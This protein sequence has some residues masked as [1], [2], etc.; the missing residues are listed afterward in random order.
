MADWK[1][2]GEVP[3]SEDEFDFDSQQ[4]TT[5]LAGLKPSKPSI[6]QDIDIWDV[7]DSGEEDNSA[8]KPIV[9]D[10]GPP[11]NSGSTS[12]LSSAMSFVEEFPA[13]DTISRSQSVGNN[14]GDD[15]Q[16]SQVIDL[17]LS[18]SV[19]KSYVQTT[20]PTLDQF[21]GGEDVGGSM[22]R[23][24]SPIRQHPLPSQDLGHDSGHGMDEA[25]ETAARLAAI[26]YERSLRPRKPI[27]EHPY[28]LEN[29]HY[30]S[31]FK[32][33]GVKPV[34]MQAD[35]VRRRREQQLSQEE[36]FQEESQ[37]SP[38]LGISDASQRPDDGGLDIYDIDFMSSSPPKTSPWINRAQGS[39]QRSSQAE[40][41]GTSVG[42]VDADLPGVN[43]L[44]LRRKSKAE[45]R[46]QATPGSEARKRRRRNV[47]DSDPVDQASGS[48]SPNGSRCV[49]GLEPIPQLRDMIALQRNS[50]TTPSPRP[51]VDVSSEDEQPVQKPNLDGDDDDKKANNDDSS[52]DS[53]GSD[54]VQDTAMNRMGKRIRGVLPASWLRLDQQSGRDK[55]QKDMNRRNRVRSPE[56]EH[57]KGVAQ[58]RQSKGAPTST[59]WPMEESEDEQ[60][61]RQTSTTDDTFHN[62]NRL[63]LKP[64][65]VPASHDISSDD[66]GSVVEQDVIDRMASGPR[67]QLNISE[68]F[69]GTTAYKRTKSSAQKDSRPL[70]RSKSLMKQ[71]KI[72]SFGS[73]TQ[74]TKPRTSSKKHRSERSQ[75]SSRRK[76]ASTQPHRPRL[77]IPRLSILD[78][79]EPDA[80]RFL[81]IAARTARRRPNQGRSS[82]SKK[83]IRLASRADHVDAMSVLNDWR[84]GQIQQRP[85]VTER[86]KQ[87]QNPKRWPLSETSANQR[88]ETHREAQR[89]PAAPKPFASV[90]RKLTK[91]TSGG[92]T[93]KYKANEPRATASTQAPAQTQPQSTSRAWTS[94]TSRPAVMEEEDIST[95]RS[96]AFHFRKKFIDRIYRRPEQQQ[97][98][99]DDDSFS[100]MDIDIPPVTFDAGDEIAIEEA[101]RE[102]Q[103][104]RFRKTRT[105]RQVDIEAPQYSHAADPVPTR[106]TLQREP[107]NEITVDAATLEKSRLRGL[108]SY[109]MQYTIHFEVFPLDTGVYFHEATLM[110]SGA[111]EKSLSITSS[112]RLLEYRPGQSFQLGQQSLHW[113]KWD[114]QVSSEFGILLDFIAEQLTVDSS[115]SS[116]SDLQAATEASK[117]ILSYV[118]KSMS[119][120]E[121]STLKLFC[122][123]VLEVLQSFNERVSKQHRPLESR[124]S[125]YSSALLRVY[126][127]LLLVALA[128]LTVCQSDPNLMNEQFQAEALVTKVAKCATSTLL[129]IGTS[130]LKSDYEELG[131]SRTR[132]RGLRNDKPLIHSW[133][134][135][136]KVLENARILRGSFWD[137]LQTLLAPPEKVMTTDVA[138]HEHIW[139]TLF[140]LLP[141]CEFNASGIILSNARYDTTMDGWAIPQRLLKRIF[142]LYSENSR[143]SPSFNN[144]CRAIIGRC[145]YLVDQW[146]WRKTAPV[147]GVIFDFFGSQNLAHLRN[148]E[149][150]RSPQFLE[151]LADQPSLQIEPT[152]K[153]F[154]IFLKLLALSIQRLRQ[155]GAIKD[156]RNLVAR[157]I[158]N[159]NREHLKE[160]NIHERDL[161]ALRNHHDLLCTLFWVAPKDMRPPVSLLERLVVPASS[162]KEACLINMRAWNQLGRFIVAKGEATTAFKPFMQWQISFFQQTLHQFD[163]VASDI[164]QQL[165]SLSKDVVQS[166]S[167]DMVD[168]MISMNKQAVADVLRAIV[169]SS[170]D[171]MKRADN[172]ESALFCLNTVQLQHV[173]K[174]FSISPPEFDWTILRAALSTLDSFV[175]KVDEFKDAEES[176]QSESQIL[177]SA[178]ADDALLVIE[179][180]LAR[181]YFAMVRCTMSSQRVDKNPSNSSLDKSACVEAAVVLAARLVRRFVDGGL[182]RLPQ[183]FKTDIYC[184]FDGQIQKLD[185]DRRRYL[186]LFVAT[187]L[188][189]GVDDLSELNFTIAELW[190]L[191]L[192]KPR[193]FLGY[194]NLL[195]DQ[196]RRRD[197]HFIPEAAVSLS[198]VPDYATNRDLVEFAIA[199]MRQSLRDAGPSLKKILLP[200]HTQTLKLVMEQMK[201]D[202]HAV[203]DKPS[204]HQS[205][206]IFVREV[207]SLIRAHG[208]E[209]CMVD[210]FYYQ[211]SREYSPSTQDP[212]LQV[213]AMVSYGLRVHDGDTKV[214]HQL[215]FFLF[216]NLKQSIINN[217]VGDE[218][219]LLQKGLRDEGIFSFVVGK[220]LPAVILAACKDST[221]YPL[222]DMYAESL[223]RSLNCR[224]M[225]RDV[226][227]NLAQ[228][229][230]L[231]RAM[232]DGMDRL[233]RSEGHLSLSQMHILRKMVSVMNLFWPSLTA[234]MAQ[235]NAA[236]EREEVEVALETFKSMFQQAGA[237]MASAMDGQRRN[238]EPDE[239]F[240]ALPPAQPNRQ[241][242]HVSSF[243][244]HIA[245]DITRNWTWTEDRINIHTAVKSK[246]TGVQ[247]VK[248]PTFNAEELMG[249]VQ[250]EIREWLYYWDRAHGVRLPIEVVGPPVIF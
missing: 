105:P 124:V 152:D 9:T 161:A 34:H 121:Q 227:K 169:T 26:R 73:S 235:T 155:V 14:E 106:H 195:A 191:C 130:Q 150:H 44:L 10:N 113:S 81:K 61:T 160:Q 60:P 215:F 35:I 101:P 31:L 128:T 15:S 120:A 33:H 21:T 112:S 212:Q 243:M 204:E 196:L 123:R 203:M 86:A 118:S 187:L 232:S 153:C 48:T 3:D 94:T 144:Y 7:P 127:N 163:S 91:Q 23:P 126:D 231:F 111:V 241:D 132:E 45:K 244:D 58:V 64:L 207:I 223:R 174:H 159:H 28:L 194:E 192:V 138:T 240:E 77:I 41:D 151:D 162:H 209:I 246:N 179:H 236:L 175:G 248:R 89:K 88:S 222:L 228:V 76:H 70:N 193:R 72:S 131:W 42:D 214:A 238:I 46:T 129:S 6:A 43:E 189:L 11:I 137:V 95:A 216:N 230:A 63:Q 182:V 208:A 2:L 27:Q 53:D 99:A 226:T 102:P 225:V 69:S 32:K 13:P 50:G 199:S 247:G 71:P 80:P 29:A 224:W 158:P 171:V 166:I 12:P 97:S 103:K 177:N 141:L 200:E 5:G 110:G 239:L 22:P 4:T 92:G 176:Q 40:T 133:V 30:S 164:Q 54:H 25:E 98:L 156:I 8:P 186:V 51:I 178:Q 16:G 85:A 157:T 206:V 20:S 78:V 83:S 104:R 181:S 167:R 55:A 234:S 67:R 172:L 107:S 168:S 18:D 87:K 84:S 136:I 19:E 115:S 134:L 38:F 47:I 198:S 74:A 108:G 75:T 68:S 24:V 250:E 218:V 116:Q 184:L 185:A 183:V 233:R 202:L 56:R 219:R 245:T 140:T 145:H 220:M 59:A 52:S 201:L 122:T 65:A 135:I 237:Y 170:L 90:P 147:V 188:Q 109:G 79:V 36:E 229:A 205:Y 117:F 93:V 139:E 210:D 211:I 1:L 66:D 37:E 146:G 149:V 217:K 213:A 143:Q 221:A 17:P 197:E 39:S 242:Q 249:S 148:E 142:Q 125:D 49:Y 165:H 154:H 119:F 100:T 62:Q 114:D 180:D 173:F 82:P 190:L 96:R 57:R